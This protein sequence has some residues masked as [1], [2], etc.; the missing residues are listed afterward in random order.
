MNLNKLT[1]KSQDALKSAQEIATNYSHQAIEP[2]H[3]F[4]AITQDSDGFASQVLTAMS[5]D[6][7]KIK[8]SRRRRIRENS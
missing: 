7:I 5:V 1:K 6:I 4:L 3:I 2:I 8:N